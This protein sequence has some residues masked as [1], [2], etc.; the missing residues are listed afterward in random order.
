MTPVE[1]IVDRIRE[2]KELLENSGTWS[3]NHESLKDI[4]LLNERIL[5]GPPKE[6]ATYH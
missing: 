3:K 6:V 2:I 5:Y 1:L 4:L